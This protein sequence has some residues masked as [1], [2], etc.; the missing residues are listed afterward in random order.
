M[1]VSSLKIDVFWLHAPISNINRNLRG[2]AFEAASRIALKVS[3]ESVML[4]RH[5]F[6]VAQNGKKKTLALARTFSISC[7][8]DDSQLV[9]AR[10]QR[11]VA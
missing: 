9:N 5:V 4:H 8:P 10:A 11:G 6:T 3:M 1:L 7:N 2:S